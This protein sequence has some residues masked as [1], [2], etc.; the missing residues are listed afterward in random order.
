MKFESLLDIKFIK[1]IAIKKNVRHFS[2]HLPGN[3]YIYK[4]F[5][6]ILENLNN[7]LTN[8]IYVYFK[9]NLLLKILTIFNI[10]KFL[11]IFF[12]INLH[13]LLK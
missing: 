9:Y 5:L 13:S 4:K 12:K 1:L 3:I 8:D 11:I 6:T 7:L 2:Y 10:I